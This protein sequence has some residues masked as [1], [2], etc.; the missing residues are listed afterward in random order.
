MNNYISI[1]NSIINDD[2][3]N[4]VSLN[5]CLIGRNALTNNYIRLDCNHEFNYIE[6]YNEIVYQKIKKTQDNIHLKL[7][8]IKC[9]YCRNVTP[10]L[11]PYYKYYG[12]KPLKGVNYPFN[13]CMTIN[14]CDYISRQT[15]KKCNESACITKFGCFC[16]KHIKFLKEDEIILESLDNEQLNIYKKKTV[17]ELKK[18]LQLN[19]LNISGNKNDLINRIFINKS[20]NTNWIE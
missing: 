14:K 20:K 6:L 1:F 4:D 18:I 8:E 15:N 2:I 16:N 12:V 11:L 10:K 7:N 3:P 9:P 5:K 19:Y 17:I 13:L